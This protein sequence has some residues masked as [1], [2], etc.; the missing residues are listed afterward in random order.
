MT[1][2]TYE[3]MTCSCDSNTFPVYCYVF[4][5]TRTASLNAAM[6]YEDHYEDAKSLSANALLSQIMIYMT[7]WN[8]DVNK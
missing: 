4:V 2:I 3:D 8:S 1:G 7:F 5:V 6:H